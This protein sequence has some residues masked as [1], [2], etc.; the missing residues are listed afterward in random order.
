MMVFY[1]GLKYLDASFALRILQYI[2]NDPEM[3]KVVCKKY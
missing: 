3:K 1:R 2:S